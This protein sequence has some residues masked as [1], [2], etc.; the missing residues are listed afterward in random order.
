MLD[1]PKSRRGFAGMSPEKR[2]AISAKGGTAVAREQRSFFTNRELARAA[3]AKGGSTPRM[4]T[5]RGK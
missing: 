3:G 2:R 5:T 4:K 1:R